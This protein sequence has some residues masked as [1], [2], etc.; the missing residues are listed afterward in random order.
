MK[1]LVTGGLGF[2]GSHYVDLVLDKHPEDVVVVV[3]SLTYAADQTRLVGWVGEKDAFEFHLADIANRDLIRWIMVDE[4][5]DSV[6][7][8]AAE[9]HVDRS[10]LASAQFLQTNVLGL[11]NLLELARE[12][13]IQRFVQ[14]STDEVYGQVLTGRSLENDLLDP[15]SPYSASKAAGDHLV[16]SYFV[17]FGLPVMLTRGSNTYGPRQ[18]PEKLVPLMATNALL[19][20]PMPVYGDGRQMRDWLHVSD[21]CQAID[22]VLRLGIPGEIYNVG[23]NNLR[24]NREIIDTVLQVTGASRDLVTHVT[25]RTGHD[26][27]YHVD[28][29]KITRDLGWEPQIKFDTGMPETVQW[30][31]DHPEWWQPIRQSEGFKEYYQRVYWQRLVTNGGKS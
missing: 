11:H 16:R 3:D 20:E 5:I 22:T 27:R 2:I 30:Y 23:G 28:S 17:S 29:R 24:E 26:R 13:G 4:E 1:I 21:H 25:D 19:G 18:Y 9:S 7:N 6:V 15:R 8:F 10:H 12:L 14:V 31:V